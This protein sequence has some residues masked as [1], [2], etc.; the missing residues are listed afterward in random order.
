MT[1][2]I[3]IK[4]VIKIGKSRRK[5]KEVVL[6]INGIYKLPDLNY[7]FVVRINGMDE[8]HDRVFQ[9]CSVFDCITHGMSYLRYHLRVYLGK[10]PGKKMYEEIYGG[11]L[12][13]QNIDEIFGTDDCVPEDLAI[14]YE[15]AKKNGYRDD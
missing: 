14:A 15:W 9:A 3:E 11:D 5:V 4:K 12:L 7:Q 6:S 13:E 8:E 2:F 10:N 1:S